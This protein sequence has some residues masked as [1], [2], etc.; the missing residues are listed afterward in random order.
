[1]KH[2]FVINPISGKGSDKA[3]LIKTI[4]SYADRFDV[5]VYVTT[6]ELD[7]TRFVK[8][9]C[10]N[11]P[12]EEVRFYACGGDGTLN[13]VV[14]G[15]VGFPNAAV[16]V[17]PC[18]SGNDYLNAHG[19]KEKFLDILGLLEGESKPVDVMRIGDRY[20]I[21]ACHF[22]FD[23][24]VAMKIVEY[25]AT[26]R[27]PYMSAVLYA[28]VHGMRTKVKIVADGELFFEGDSL[29]CT[30]CNGTHVGGSYRCAP[31]SVSDDGLL[32]LCLM[33]TVSRLGLLSRM[34]LYER[35]EHLD[36]PRFKGIVEYRRCRRV[37]IDVPEGFGVSLDGEII[38]QPHIVVEN[39]EK[40]VRFVV[41]K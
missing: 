13:E 2:V 29:M 35:G 8:E 30:I 11:H 27:D 10:T 33:R 18:G 4:Q 39:L 6:G 34:G 3:P 36:S 37:E 20:A 31:R 38:K 12:E 5:D 14:N 26:K 1:M 40:A 24:H 22:G 41:P 17:Y 15:L 19:P 7:A 32:E 16:G 25:R 21:N 28:I 9:Y 23:S